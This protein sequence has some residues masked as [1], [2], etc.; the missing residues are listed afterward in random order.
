[1][2]S[3]CSFRSLRSV[4]DCAGSACTPIIHQTRRIHLL[5]SFIHAPSSI[6]TGSPFHAWLRLVLCCR[7]VS[8]FAFGI[9]IRGPFRF[10]HLMVFV[11]SFIIVFL[12]CI[13]FSYFSHG[14]VSSCA[15]HRFSFPFFTTSNAK[16]SLFSL[17][18]FWSYF[19]VR[20]A[21]WRRFARLL[22]PAICCI[23]ST[24][25]ISVM[26]LGF[27]FCRILLLLPLGP[28]N[29]RESFCFL[30]P[31][32]CNL[33]RTEKGMPSVFRFVV[34]LRISDA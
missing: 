34:I 30:L 5:S 23:C 22:F 12:S 32:Y 16:I 17:I 1:M 21:E 10:V 25:A 31:T 7:C 9:C 19:Y 11:A 27:P 4:Q 26:I 2:R 6:F 15:V 33:H 28:N 13:L 29:V 18:C 14:A 3:L 8:L 20:Y 24:V